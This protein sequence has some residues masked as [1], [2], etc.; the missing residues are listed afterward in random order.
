[1]QHHSSSSTAGGGYPPRPAN[2][3][4]GDE[5]IH[6]SAPLLAHAAPDVRFGIP[7]SAS[8]PAVRYQLSDTGRG[9]GG[10]S[11][12][13]L[14]GRAENGVEYENGYGNGGLNGYGNGGLNGYG[15][16]G[17]DED[18]ETMVHYGPVPVRVMRRNRTQKRVA[19]VALFTHPHTS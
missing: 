6:D 5:D 2:L 13:G 17:G 14:P 3:S 19:L 16:G 10:E 7:Q 12:I 9:A 18:D 4:G 8:R 11:D 15:G 1:M